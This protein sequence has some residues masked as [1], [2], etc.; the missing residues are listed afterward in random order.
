MH[1]ARMERDAYRILVGKPEGNV[2][3]RSWVHNIEMALQEVG[4]RHGMDSSGSG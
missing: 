3:R 2:P 1:V 4:W